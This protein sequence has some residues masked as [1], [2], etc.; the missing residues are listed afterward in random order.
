MAQ[1]P[2]TASVRSVSDP[3]SLVQK[4]ATLLY[5]VLFFQY[6]CTALNACRKLLTG[7]LP[8]EKDVALLNQGLSQEFL[9]MRPKRT[10][11]HY[12]SSTKPQEGEY[13]ITF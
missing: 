13:I 4:E 5:S 8:K 2:H 7:S 11:A 10:T 12:S 1:S 3:G 9:I 6:L